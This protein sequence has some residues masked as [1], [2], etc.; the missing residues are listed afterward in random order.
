MEEKVTQLQEEIE[1]MADMPFD[2]IVWL[3]PPDYHEEGQTGQSVE[4]MFREDILKLLKEGWSA[5]P[6]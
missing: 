5:I 2:T 4:G 6:F 3:L 1:Q